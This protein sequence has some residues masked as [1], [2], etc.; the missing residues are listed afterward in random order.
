MTIR[1]NKEVVTRWFTEYWGKLNPDVADELAADD[2][3]LGYPLGE[4]RGREEARSRILGF[5]EM[6]PEG[7]FEL[8]DELIAEGDRVVARWE[9]GGTHT[10]P[11]WELSIGVLPEASG[12]TMRYTG[13]TVYRVRD[14]RIAEAHGEGDYLKEMRQLGLVGSPRE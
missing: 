1:G 10:G 3:L 5:R 6:F 7:G 12:E 4:T 13:T 2:L 8:T 14:G 9:G 11:A